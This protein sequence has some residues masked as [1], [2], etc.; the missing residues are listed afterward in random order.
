[1]EDFGDERAEEISPDERPPT[2][3]AAEWASRLISIALE[4]VI[5]GCLGW[6]CDRWLGVQPLMTILGFFGGM[7]LAMW[8]L[9][10]I[11]TKKPSSH[12]R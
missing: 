3:R 10:R 2:V 9:L 4:M 6:A 12:G 8:H 5:P 11:T 7:I 1:M